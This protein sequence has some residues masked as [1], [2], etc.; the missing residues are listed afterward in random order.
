MSVKYRTW[1][2]NIKTG[3]KEIGHEDTGAIYLDQDSVQSWSVVNNDMNNFN[4]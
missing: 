4:F 3:F 1:E 2:D